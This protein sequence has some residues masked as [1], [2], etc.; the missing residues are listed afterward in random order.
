MKKALVPLA[1]LLEGLFLILAFLPWFSFNVELTGGYRPPLWMVGLLL[2]A[3]LVFHLCLKR[4]TRTADTVLLG[5]VC[6]LSPM[7]VVV[8]ALLVWEERMN[9]AAGFRLA[10]SLAAAQPV[11]YIECVLAVLILLL[12]LAGVPGKKS[13]AE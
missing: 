12:G 1:L 7:A 6:A 9:I 11:F 10:D 3:F 13:A 5:E 4:E 8:Y 2:A